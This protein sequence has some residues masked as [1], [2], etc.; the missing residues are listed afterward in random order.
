M[1]SC[2]VK[3]IP[4]LEISPWDGIKTSPCEMHSAGLRNTNPGSNKAFWILFMTGRLLFQMFHAKLN[5]MENGCR[6]QSR[7]SAFC[8]APLSRIMIYTDLFIRFSIFFE[9]VD[10]IENWGGNYFFQHLDRAREQL[11]FQS[12]TVSFDRRQ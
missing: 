10:K 6:S 5:T 12:E 2:K 3:L 8:C 4:N 7:T 9:I 11:P 1:I